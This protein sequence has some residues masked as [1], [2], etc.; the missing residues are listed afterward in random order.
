MS[1]GLSSSEI[2]KLINKK[3]GLNV[4]HNLKEDNPTEVKE[5][6]PTGS[7]WLDSIT[8]KGKYAGIPIGKFCE[9]AGLESTGKSFLAAQVAANAQKM[10]M[11]VIYFDSESAVDPQFLER[12]GCNLE[13]F[14]YVQASSVEFVLDTIELLLSEND[15]KMLFIWDSMAMTPCESDIASD[16][17]PQSTMAV[18]PRVMAKAMSKIAV[19]LANSKSTLLV[20]NQLKT[21]IG[22]SM[23]RAMTSVY[24]TP[25]GKALS[26]A[27]SL[28]I[29]LTGKKSKDSYILDSKGYRV[30]SEVKAT[31][32]KS[33]F[34]SEG[35][36]CN[37]KIIWGDNI[38]GVLDEE[39]WLEALKGTEYLKSSGP[40]FSLTYADGTQEKFQSSKW[41]EK[42]ESKKFKDRI[43]E[44]MD[45]EVITKFD[46]RQGNAKDFYDVQ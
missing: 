9:I 46:K 18:K 44:L 33:R 29:W 43:L 31:I 24:F 8:C 3:A 13:S 21:N 45:A 37:F 41:L 5:W 19:P 34:G 38:V 23:S 7:R 4:S 39:S 26:Y 15:N 35:R 40:W 12:A 22:N 25:G 42:L 27:Y 16:F 20:L 11:S 36:T 1:N 10:G 32:V 17:N 2:N 6:I 30:G 28:R 14:N